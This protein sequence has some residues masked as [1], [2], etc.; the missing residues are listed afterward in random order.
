M[1]YDSSGSEA[2]EG[3]ERAGPSNSQ[4]PD[5]NAATPRS[6]S[7][8]KRL[9]VL[10]D[11][12]DTFPSP[13]PIRPRRNLRPTLHR[14]KNKVS[15]IVPARF[16]LFVVIAHGSAKNLQ[17]LWLESISLRKISL[18]RYESEEG[19]MKKPVMKSGH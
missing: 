14:D 15:L 12:V 13:S 5:H 19:I 11:T 7:P 9:R 18:I 4:S 8:R 6:T 2:E 3:G 16:C 17:V 1:G 10:D